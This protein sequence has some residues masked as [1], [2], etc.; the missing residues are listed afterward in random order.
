M[1]RGSKV[2]HSAFISCVETSCVLSLVAQ[3]SAGIKW[4][5][6][7]VQELQE[8]RRQEFRRQEHRVRIALNLQTGKIAAA[9]EPKVRSFYSE[10]LNS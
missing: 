6:S 9:Y 5:S 7:G 2:R 10:L 4:R 8:F 3:G 1:Y